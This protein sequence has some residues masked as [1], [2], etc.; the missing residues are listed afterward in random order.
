MT[1][2]EVV[3]E[4]TS[5][6]VELAPDRTLIEELVPEA[7]AHP[8]G[9]RGEVLL[10]VRG[11]KTSFHLREGTV[12]AVTGVNFSVR[13]GEILGLVGESGCGK[14]VSSLSIMTATR[15]LTCFTTDRSWAMN[16]YVRLRRLRRSVRRLST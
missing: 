4:G 5:A 13:R 1:Q 2:Q 15:S 14:S 7:A 11:L 12:R 6:T 3:E 10:D 16:R 9:I 8:K